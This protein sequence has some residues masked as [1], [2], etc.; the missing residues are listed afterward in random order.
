MRCSERQA[1]YFA[2][3][4]TVTA[5]RS[6]SELLAG[7][8]CRTI[9]ADFC[10]SLLGAKTI[11]SVRVVGNLGTAFLSDATDGQQQNDVVTYGASVARALTDR[12]EVVAEVNGRI[13]LTD[14]P[15]P[16]TESAGRLNLGGR[17]TRGLIRFDGGLFFGLTSV[18]PTIGF[19][20]GFTY[21]FHAFDVP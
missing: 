7:C 11:Q 13:S 9:S 21:V 8:G 5:I 14:V 2:A 18:D 17:Y 20:A 16:G 1:G 3:G 19:T 4:A 10:A 12:S 15:F 6:T